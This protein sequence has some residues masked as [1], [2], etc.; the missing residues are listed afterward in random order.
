[1]ISGNYIK[2]HDYNINDFIYKMLW[3]IILQGKDYWNLVK[4]FQ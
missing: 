2:K 3:K 1:M 4:Y